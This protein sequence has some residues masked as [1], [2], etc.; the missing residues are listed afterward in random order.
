MTYKVMAVI[1]PKRGG[2][3]YIVDLFFSAA[4]TPADVEKY[5]AA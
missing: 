4:P 5:L 3:D 1:H 2:D